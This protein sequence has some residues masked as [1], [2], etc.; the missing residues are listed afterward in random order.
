MQDTGCLRCA[1][2]VDLNYL[3]ISCCRTVVLGNSPKGPSISLTSGNSLPSITISLDA[4]TRTSLV[5]LLA[6][7][8]VVS[9]DPSYFSS[10]VFNG[11]IACDLQKQLDLTNT[12]ETG[13]GSF[14]LRPFHK[15]Y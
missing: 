12:I 13:E 7:F 6:T 1:N 9:I 11:R 8:E 10:S 4:G 3:S 5:M 2:S 14:F 15:T